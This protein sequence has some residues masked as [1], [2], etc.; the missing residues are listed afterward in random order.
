[1]ALSGKYITWHSMD[2]T[3]HDTQWKKPYMTL[4]GRH[5]TWLSVED[6]LHGSQWKTHYTNTLI[7]QPTQI[8]RHNFIKLIVMQLR[9]CS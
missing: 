3:L 1:M 5:I 7:V 2:E 4:N 8:Q 6:T 9:D